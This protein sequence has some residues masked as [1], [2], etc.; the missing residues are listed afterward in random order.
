MRGDEVVR[1]GACDARDSNGGACGAVSAS[2]SS[3]RRLLSPRL[4][5]LRL[6]GR[7]GLARL[8]DGG[9]PL[10]TPSAA[11]LSSASRI[12]LLW[13]LVWPGMNFRTPL[14]PDLLLPSRLRLEWVL[15]RVGDLSRLIESIES[16]R[17][18]LLL[19]LPG[20]S[21]DRLDFESTFLNLD[22][23]AGEP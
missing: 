20:S 7:G 8:A 19:P 3:V 11:A 2:E 12:L 15:A 1:Y 14:L 22:V 13:R 16:V 23:I 5:A 6:R 10:V 21:E 17:R 9:R 4:L 18:T